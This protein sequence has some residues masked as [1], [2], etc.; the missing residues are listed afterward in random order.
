VVGALTL[1]SMMKIGME[2][3]WKPHPTR[4]EPEHAITMVRPALD[5]LPAYAVIIGLATLTLWIGLWPETLI[6]FSQR[7]I[8]QL[9]QTP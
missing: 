6:Q 7:A 9:V 3:F 5:L 2:T 4:S 1:Y 8:E